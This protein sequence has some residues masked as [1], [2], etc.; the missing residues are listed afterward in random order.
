[1]HLLSLIERH[2]RRSGMPPTRFGRE[3]V[4]DPR[5]VFDLRNGRQPGPKLSAKV[6]AYIEKCEPAGEQRPCSR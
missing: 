6:A 1:M 2:L 4:H 3:S 5:F